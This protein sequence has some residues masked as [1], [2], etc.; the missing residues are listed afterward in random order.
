[1]FFFLRSYHCVSVT[2]CYVDSHHD[3]FGMGRNVVPLLISY[4][5]NLYSNADNLSFNA[6]GKLREL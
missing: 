2:V 3:V 6:E 4:G 1:M 5:H